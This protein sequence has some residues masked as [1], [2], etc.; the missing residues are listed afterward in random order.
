M[1]DGQKTVLITGCSSGIGYASAHVMRERG[2]RVFPACRKEADVA[3]LREEG[4]EAVRI[5]YADTDSILNGLAE[6][7]EAT[8]GRLDG[9]FNN[10]AQGLPGPV[11]D[12][13]TEALRAVFEVNVFGQHE[14]TRRVIPVMRA[15]GS[16]RIV[17][18]SSVLGFIVYPWRGGYNASKFALEGLVQTLRIEMRDTPIRVSV[19]QPGP[20]KT[21]II[22]NAAPQFDKWVDWENSA[23]AEQYRDSLLEKLYNP[24]PPGIFTRPPEVVAKAL[25][26]ALESRRPRP[27]YMITVPTRVSNV[28]KRLLPWRLHDWLL[29]RA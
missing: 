20:I 15:Q 4:F 26:H 13:P 17:F 7:L 3:R 22:H 14:L 8:G 9:L 11:E 2:W 24:S 18:T 5:D 16:G 28:L 29:A 21:K 1:S 27:V 12:V 6:V 23:R 10:G 25:A 19:I